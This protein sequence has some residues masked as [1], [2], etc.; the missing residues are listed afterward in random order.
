MYDITLQPVAQTTSPGL[1]LWMQLATHPGRAPPSSCWSFIPPGPP[2]QPP[3]VALAAPVAS[4]CCSLPSEWLHQRLNAKPLLCSKTSQ[5]PPSVSRI[6]SRGNFALLADL[7]SPCF[8]PEHVFSLCSGCKDASLMRAD[9]PCFL[10]CFPGALP[11]CPPGMLPSGTP[12]PSLRTSWIMPNSGGM[13]TVLSLLGHDRAPSHHPGL[14]IS[15]L[16]SSRH[17]LCLTVAR[18]QPTPNQNKC[19]WNGT[20]EKIKNTLRRL[21]CSFSLSQRN[22]P[23]Q[24]RHR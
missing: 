24:R 10:M 7:L 21:L 11:A 19:I 12:I 23:T 6:R 13:D 14:F 17:K 5:A 20:S 22:W 3:C 9:M 4:L 8:S 18:Y 2:C 15:C 1:T 16:S